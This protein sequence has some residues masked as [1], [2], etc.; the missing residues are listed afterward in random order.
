M[1]IKW[2]VCQVP[3]NAR[4]A[5]SIAQS[6][7]SALKGMPGFLGQ[8]GGWTSASPQQAG[9][10]ACWQDEASYLHF[11]QSMHNA[12]FEQSRQKGTYTSLSIT[13]FEELMSIAGSQSDLQA[14]LATGT[15]LRVTDSQ[16]FPQRDQLFIHNQKTI[17]NPGMMQ[18]SGMYGGVFAQAQDHSSRYLVAT[19]WSDLQAHQAYREALFPHLRE[20]ANLPQTLQSIHGWVL[21]L[22]KTWQV[23]V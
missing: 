15:V 22:E 19:L 9:I 6:Q 1:L 3:A 12:L 16:L 4:R 18:A 17:W 7:W 14:A 21:Q 2:I 5:F 13:L 8:I 20:K 10:L 23:L 11:M